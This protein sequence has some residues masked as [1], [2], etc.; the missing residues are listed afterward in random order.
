MGKTS[1]HFSE[2]LFRF[3]KNQ[4]AFRHHHE[5]RLQHERRLCNCDSA[6]S[7]TFRDNRTKNAAFSVPNIPKRLLDALIAIFLVVFS[8][9]IASLGRFSSHKAGADGDDIV[10]YLKTHTETTDDVL[11]LGND[12]HYNIESNR[13]T[14]Q[15]FFYQTPICF[16]NPAFFAEFQTHILSDRPDYIVCT[17]SREIFLQKEQIHSLLNEIAPSY[18]KIPLSDGYILKKHTK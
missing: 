9:S 3:L 11:V 6:N 10:S 16:I 13:F 5:S 2:C 1:A 8:F 18:D 7:R 4:E 15:R 12:V 17:A 14:K